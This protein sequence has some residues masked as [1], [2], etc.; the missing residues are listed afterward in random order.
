MEKIHFKNFASKVSKASIDPFD[1]EAVLDFIRENIRKESFV[2]FGLILLSAPN[3][4]EFSNIITKF[5]HGY[6]P[7]LPKN[8]VGEILFRIFGELDDDC[9]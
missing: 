7:E 2:D 6:L 1:V 9:A 4:E 3:E 5:A 8:Q